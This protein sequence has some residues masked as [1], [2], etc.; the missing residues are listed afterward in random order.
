MPRGAWLSSCELLVR[1]YVHLE[2]QLHTRA[3]RLNLRPPMVAVMMD[4]ASVDE[5]EGFTAGCCLVREL[6]QVPS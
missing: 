3:L 1:A 5:A 6:P 2:R 4:G